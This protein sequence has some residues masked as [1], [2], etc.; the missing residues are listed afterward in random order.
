MSSQAAVPTTSAAVHVPVAAM[1]S[2]ASSRISPPRHAAAWNASASRISVDSNVGLPANSGASPDG[3]AFARSISGAWV[4]D[5]LRRG[6]TVERERNNSRHSSSA[7][8][9]R[10]REM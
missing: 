2:S 9:T 1:T 10:A 8:P 6:E 7:S 4:D 3:C 5:R